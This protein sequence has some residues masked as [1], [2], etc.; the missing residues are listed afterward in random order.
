MGT[1]VSQI[2]ILSIVCSTAC[3]GADQRKH[4]NPASLAFV[5]GIHWW[6]VKFPHKGPVTR[7]MFPFDDVIMMKFVSAQP[8]V[9]EE[10]FKNT[11]DCS[12]ESLLMMIQPL[13]YNPIQ[14]YMHIC[15][16]HHG[17]ITITILYFITVTA[18][19]CHCISKSPG[20]LLF[21]Q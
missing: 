21:A 17:M 14:N 12:H 5:R 4:Q 6:P 16:I 15:I 1:M 20:T 9:S 19:E 13:Q 3:S 8:S 18:H 11:S 10:K 2:T 7:K